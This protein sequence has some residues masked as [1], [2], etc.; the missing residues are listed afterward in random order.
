MTA[1]ATSNGTLHVSRF[2]ITNL[3]RIEA[4]DWKIDGKHLLLSG[5]NGSGKSSA[6]SAFWWALGGLSSKEIPEVIRRGET[7]GEARIELTN[8]AGQVEF[9]IERRATAKSVTL[10]VTAGD[11]SKV[12]RPQELLD[13]LIDK[14]ALDIS[15]F[16]TARNQDQVDDVLKLGD[17]A[18]PVARVEKITG[19]RFEPAPDESAEQYLMRLSRDDTGL[20]YNDRR[21]AKQVS[22]QKAKALDEQRAIVQALPPSDGAASVSDLLAERETLQEAA[23]KRA[24]ADLAARRAR[25]D[26]EQSSRKL[27]GIKTDYDKKRQEIAEYESKLEQARADLAKLKDAG[28]Q[29]EADT[30]ELHATADRMAKA[31]A[32]MEDPAIRLA[33]LDAQIKR[34]DETTRAH[35]TRMHAEEELARIESEYKAAEQDHARLD[36]ALTELRNLR[37]TLLDGV[38]LGVPGLSVGDGELRL[39][40]IPFRQASTAQRIR[41]ACALAFKRNPRLKILRLDDAEHLDAESRKVLGEMAEQYGWQ[42]MM[43]FVRDSGDLKVEIVEELA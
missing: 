10:T 35:A 8:D 7:K 36:L 14:C 32:A 28:K 2:A 5:K 38:D 18:C 22:V 29:C 9:I 23:R 12:S 39:N 1:T 31:A 25:M 27:M 6:L 20:V 17:V 15:K 3:M 13:S 41:V 33:A 11:G 19:Q 40:D 16:L 43:G 37:R 24:D 21:K 26:A 30:S 42:L 34:A 4:A